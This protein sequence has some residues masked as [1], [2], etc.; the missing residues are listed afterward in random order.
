[1]PIFEFRCRN[2]GE[3]FELLVRSGSDVE[4]PHCK[5]AD[6]SKLFSVFGFKSGSAFVSSAGKDSCGSCSH[7]HCST[8]GH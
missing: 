1:M 3:K 8:C 2:C 6:V 5:S 4:C 7:H